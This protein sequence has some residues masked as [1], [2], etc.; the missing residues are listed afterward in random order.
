[1]LRRVCAAVVVPSVGIPFL[2]YNCST[3]TFF[4]LGSFVEHPASP[5]D[6]QKNQEGHKL[7]FR[8]GHFSVCT[9]IHI[10]IIWSHFI[11]FFSDCCILRARVLPSFLS[12][13][14]PSCRLAHPPGAWWHGKKDIL[15]WSGHAFVCMYNSLKLFSR[16]KYFYCHGV[17]EHRWSCY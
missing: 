5:F 4:S 6:A 11:L 15:L 14:C 13:K 8:G 12:I 16:I 10:C 9:H 17:Y 1:M 7:S 3:N 2:P